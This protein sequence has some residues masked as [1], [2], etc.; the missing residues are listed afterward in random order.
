MSLLLAVQSAGGDATAPTI[1][2]AYSY[3]ATSFTPVISSSAPTVFASYT[4]A[5]STLPAIALAPIV[6]AGYTY[7]GSVSAPASTAAIVFGGYTYSAVSL[8]PI[9]DA[10]AALVFAGYTYSAASSTPTIGGGATDATAPTVFANRTFTAVSST[11]LTDAAPGKDLDAGGW[12]WRGYDLP[13]QNARAPWVIPNAR[14]FLAADVVPIIT[15]EA[16]DVV[17][18]AV[19]AERK[20]TCRPSHPGI[21]QM[22]RSRVL[23]KSRYLLNGGK[24]IEQH[25]IRS[26]HMKLIRSK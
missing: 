4:Y 3:S 16:S 9:I 26:T 1:A 12:G 23:I 14:V 17:A 21:A 8:T 13:R 15:D 10:S 19:Y 18:P 20:I 24:P 25:M 5:G 11:P 7:S 2:A 22:V 6:F